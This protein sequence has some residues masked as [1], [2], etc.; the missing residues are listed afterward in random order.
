MKIK[1]AQPRVWGVL[2]DAGGRTPATSDNKN[3]TSK[4]EDEN[5]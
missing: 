4:E 5:D 3:H 1:K 2:T